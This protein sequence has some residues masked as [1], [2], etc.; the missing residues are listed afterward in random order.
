MENYFDIVLSDDQ[1]RGISSIGLAHMGDAVFEILVRGWL[2]AHGKE[3]GKGIHRAAIELVCAKE[4]SRRAELILPH[5]TEEEQAVFRRGRNAHVHRIPNN[6]SRHDYQQATALE[7]L[8]GYL[9]LNG[10]KDR[11]NQ[12][13][14]MMMEEV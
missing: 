5:L 12:L 11:V 8:F 10:C 7:A 6:T 1:V 3:T 13:F 2:C 4:Q 9:Y 14:L